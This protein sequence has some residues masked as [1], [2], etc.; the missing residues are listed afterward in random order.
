MKLDLRHSSQCTSNLR[1]KP[2]K[3][4]DFRSS[5]ILRRA[6]E[7]ASR[8]MS[9]R[10]RKFR[11]RAVHNFWAV[12]TVW[13]ICSVR[14]LPV[15]CD[16]YIYIFSAFFIIMCDDYD[17]FSQY[18]ATFSTKYVFTLYFSLFT[19]MIPTHLML[20]VQLWKVPLRFTLHAF[21]F[22]LLINRSAH[23]LFSPTDSA[24]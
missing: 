9:R 20:K 14:F 12:C 6:N 21:W 2:W 22:E 19:V 13:Y 7:M 1:R 18:L 16:D 24:M 8:G 23:F 3:R 15:M 17:S 5:H 11:A 4:P 10:D